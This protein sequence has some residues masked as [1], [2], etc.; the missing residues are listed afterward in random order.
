[1]SR[2]QRRDRSGNFL[3]RGLSRTPKDGYDVLINVPSNDFDI[4]V[5]ELSRLLKLSGQDVRPRIEEDYGSVLDLCT[6]LHTS[7]TDGKSI[8]SVP[9]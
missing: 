2:S 6:Q 5:E 7:P 3:I 4:P 1:M 9:V 8:S